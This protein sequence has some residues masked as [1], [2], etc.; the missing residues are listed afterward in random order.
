MR[1]DMQ[2]DPVKGL[3]IVN[4]V[5]EA[6]KKLY[7]VVKGLKDHETKQKLDEILD[8][9]RELK[10]Q[11]A[12]LEDQNRDLREKLRFKS[13]EFEFKNPFYYEK[14]HPEQALCPKCFAQQVA[15]PME[16]PYQTHNGVYAR[17]L[18]CGTSVEI[19]RISRPASSS[20]GGS[21]G[22]HSWM[23]R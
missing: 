20:Y 23:G 7:A 9:L 8:E 4:G 21:G 6:T 22:P 15:A 2:L 10:K 12:E 14:T 19:E 1:G 16:K 3:T 13:D 11:A 17:C 18:V 5:A